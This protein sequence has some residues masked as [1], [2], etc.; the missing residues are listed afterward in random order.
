MIDMFEISCDNVTEHFYRLYTCS[1]YITERIA[2]ERY[3]DTELAIILFFVNN[4]N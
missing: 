2:R 3:V 1:C 4:N